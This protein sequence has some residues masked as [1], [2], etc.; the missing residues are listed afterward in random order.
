[1]KIAVAQLNSFVGDVEGNLEK[2]IRLIK[3]TGLNADLIITPELFL[4]GYPPWDLLEKPW[5]MNKTKRALEKL[6]EISKQFPETGILTGAPT[7]AWAATGKNLYNSAI[8]IREGKV[9]FQQHKSLLPTYDVF[10]EARYFIPAPEIDVISFK[11]EKLG[12]TVCEDVW[13]DPGLWSEK[14]MYDFDPVE[15]LV[16]KG[17]TLLVNISASPFHVGKEGVRYKLLRDHAQKNQIPLVFVNQVG[18]NDELIFDGR[19]MGFDKGG[20]P[21]FI[22][23][24]FKEK[25]EL[26]DMEGR[27]TPGLYIPQDKTESIYQA[28]VL[29]TRDYLKK[30]G[31]S[32]TI[33]GLSGGID[34]GV[35]CCIAVDA[36]GKENVLGISM[37]SPY[38]SRGSVEDSQ[39]LARNLGI[40]FKVIDISQIYYSYLD[41]LKEHFMGRGEDVTEE[42]IQARIRGNILMAFSN[43]LGHLVLTTGNKSEISV[44]Y[45][46]LYGDMAG[47]LSV[48]SDVPKQEVFSL[49]HYINRQREVIPEEIIIKAPSAELKPGQLDEDTL[50]P[51]EILDQ[52]LNYYVE[53]GYSSEEIISLGLDSEM[54]KGI[55]R[56]VDKNEYKRKQAPPGLRVTTKAYGVGRK[57]PIAAKHYY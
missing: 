27:G 21:V 18:G 4:T 49:A 12:I 19:S 3:E 28:L 25:T 45:C 6:R 57:M 9:L 38:S 53:E 46:T 34:S 56:A 10:D 17:A 37:P 20:E 42:N 2:I 36:L 31:F 48:L 52:V 51:Y 39:K 11:G 5:F 55:I 7:Y 16:E 29:G 47:G 32:R 24:S 54:V 35:T 41:H 40:D 23:P 8:L 15:E 30:S 33:L 43:K 1:M 14:Q 13:N 22:F 50:P 26:I 44:G